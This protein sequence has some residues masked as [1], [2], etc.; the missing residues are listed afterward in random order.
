MVKL[1][2]YL[3]LKQ[4]TDEAQQ[5]A[6]KCEGALSQVMKQLKSKFKCS[7]LK[8]AEKKLKQLQDKDAALTIEFDE[9]IL[10]F[11]KEWGVLE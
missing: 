7:T 9:A 2:K 6:D 1:N 11:E 3:K 4:A 5:K 8:A 10:A